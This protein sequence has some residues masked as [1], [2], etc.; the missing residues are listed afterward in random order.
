[1]V[2]VR[3]NLAAIDRAGYQQIDSFTLPESDWWDRF[4]RDLSTELVEFKRRHPGNTDEVHEGQALIEHLEGEM[5][6]LRESQAS[7][8]YVFYIMRKRD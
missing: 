5:D 8:S 1:M 6:T 2:N 7:Y 4:Y 3:D